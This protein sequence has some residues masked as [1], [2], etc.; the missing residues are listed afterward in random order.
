[1]LERESIRALD[2][3]TIAAGVASIDLMERAGREIADVLVH[4]R[5]DRPPTLILAGAGNNGGDGYVVARLLRERGWPVELAHVGKAARPGSECAVNAERWRERGGEVLDAAGARAWIEDADVTTALT[6]DA[7]FGTGLD[8]AVEGEAAEL[9]DALGARDLFTVAVDV[10]SGLDANSGRPL[11]ACV[12][13]QVTITVGAAKP[14]LFLGEG[15]DRAGRVEIV[16]I[17]LRSPG[18]AAVDVA[19]AALD[20]RSVAPLLP[21][22]ARTAHKGSRGHVLV[23]G[24]SPGK[25]GAVALAARG[26]LRAGAG[27]VTMAVPAGLA[28]DVDAMLPEAMTLAL[29]DDGDGCVALGAWRAIERA[30]SEVGF[31]V[32]VIGPGLGNAEGS[33]SLVLDAL[34]HFAGAI[35]I[36]AD[37]LN[38][39]ARDAGDLRARL[40]RRRARGHA[41]AILTPHPGEMARLIA[42]DSAAVQADRA[43]VARDF[44]RAHDAVLV[45][46]GA[47]TLVARDGELAFNTSGNP[48]MAAAG[49]GDVLAGAVAGFATRIRPLFDAAAAAVFVH[50]R[51]GDLAT[52]RIGAF[53]F[54]SGEVADLLPAAVDT[55]VARSPT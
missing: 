30:Q 12:R 8:R 43:T 41:G 29:A 32:L 2:Q 16:D 51:A 47:G 10:P 24:A 26:A 45:L 46:K 48:G 55:L 31:D 20:A 53:G 11:G 39:L 50:G 34:Q 4:L 44:A 9:I 21:R 42:S 18:E 6:V 15:P 19:G 52:A 27:L 54:L 13:A 7:L 23:V 14:G 1:V 5:S 22:L 36:D 28:H 3:L 25:T 17:D 37:A 40:A 35:V 33:E 49:M 38:A